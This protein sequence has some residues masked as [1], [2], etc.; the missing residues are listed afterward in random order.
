[1][2]KCN[3]KLIQ[4]ERAYYE[5]RLK[6]FTLVELIVVIAI[7]GVLAT[8]LIPTLFGKVKDARQATANANAKEIFDTLNYSTIEL[9]LADITL[10]DFTLSD[11]GQS[12]DKGDCVDLDEWLNSGS[13][14]PSQRASMNLTV[15]GYV[16]IVYKGGVPVAVAWS[17]DK[18]ADAIIGRFPEQPSIDDGVTWRNWDANVDK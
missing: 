16:D 14:T 9:E 5:K 11:S 10:L 4:K 3:W 13:F 2:L 17:K 15:G 8:I 7:I 12:W 1:M 6:G 18:G